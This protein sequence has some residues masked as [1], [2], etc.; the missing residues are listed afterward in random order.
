MYSLILAMN[1]SL[2]SIIFMGGGFIVVK[3]LLPYEIKPSEDL[4]LCGKDVI[5]HFPVWN[6]LQGIVVVY[7]HWSN[8]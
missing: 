5:Q 2:L 4:E 3:N 1:R 8:K 7:T 6:F